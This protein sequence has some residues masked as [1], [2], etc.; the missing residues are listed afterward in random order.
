MKYKREDHNAQR[1]LD[2]IKALTIGWITTIGL[3][4]IVSLLLYK[5]QLSE[6]MVSISAV[7]I[8]V[9]S[10]TII[11][12]LS[13]RRQDSKIIWSIAGGLLYYLSLLG[14]NA[15]I[16]DGKYNGLLA[17]LLTITG[18]SLV[19]GL[20]LARQKHQRPVYTKTRIKL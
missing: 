11:A 2:M 6:N 14:C 15:L 13:G 4:A 7:I 3:S 9:I 1:L 12:F 8:T 18:C 16:F 10:S 20:A 5:E 17:S 19:C